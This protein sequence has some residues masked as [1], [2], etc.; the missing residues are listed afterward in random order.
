MKREDIKKILGQDVDPELINELLDKFHLEI[1]AK[2]N[3]IENKYRNL[4]TELDNAK[5]DLKTANA[6]I[7]KLQKENP[8]I[9]ELQQQ[10][11]KYQ[12][13]NQELEEQRKAD[14]QERDT[15]F[16]NS[17]IE[18]DL[19]KH[20]VKDVKSAM[21]HYDKSKIK[22]DGN[23]KITGITDQTEQIVK[24][25]PFLFGRSDAAK[26]PQQDYSPQEGKTAKPSFGAQLAQQHI[27]EMEERK[28][29]VEQA[30]KT[31]F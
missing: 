21:V 20:Q 25:K 22:I 7:R 15:E 16:I 1:E 9:E 18:N 29:A 11:E 12:K 24:D 8:D 2:S 23:R 30:L 28:A 17:A 3:E 4:E 19:I 13:K 14:Q 27:K 26:K 6:T 10:I 5:T 31:N